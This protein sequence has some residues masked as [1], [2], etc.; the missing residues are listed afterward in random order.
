MGPKMAPLVVGEFKDEWKLGRF[1][2]VR[3][4]GAG[5]KAVTF[6][7]TYNTPP[8]GNDGSMWQKQVKVLN[9]SK[10]ADVATR[11]WE[12][13]G[14]KM[15]EAA[16]RGDEVIV[17]GDTNTLISTKPD[18]GQRASGRYDAA[19][20][21]RTK[22]MRRALRLHG[23]RQF[24]QRY[25][26]EAHRHTWRRSQH[27]APQS[28][29]DH[30]F[31]TGNIVSKADGLVVAKGIMNN[32]DHQL[33]MIALKGEAV[34]G[35]G[36]GGGVEARPYREAQIGYLR[37]SGQDEEKVEAYKKETEGRWE[38]ENIRRT[39]EALTQATPGAG[40]TTLRDPRC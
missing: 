25:A 3:I 14:A 15:T 24:T 2:G 11:H 1:C 38:D 34:L 40:W 21:S 27:S 4:R 9:V 28:T 37:G 13:M 33:I 32:S 31:G 17:G 19:D 10:A 12:H 35:K 16:V 36:T 22:G 29:I 7:S 6:V 8:S 20:E 26:V 39:V 30:F 18:S 23:L 5:Q